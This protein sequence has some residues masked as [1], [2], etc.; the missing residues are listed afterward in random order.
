[1]LKKV[2][3]YYCLLALFCFPALAKEKI[4][5]GQWYKIKSEILQEMRPYSIYLPPTYQTQKDKLYPVIYV[6]D[7]DETKLKALSGLMESFTVEK[8]VVEH[9]IVAIPNI[10]IRERNLTPTNNK[11]V[12]KDKVLDDFGPVGNA[13]NFISFFEKELIPN[14]NLNFRT[15]P[16]RMLIGHS[17][18]GLFS[19]Y[20][21]LIKPNLFTDYL[22]IDPTSLWDNNFLNR[23]FIDLKYDEQ[24]PKANVY[25]SFANN[26]H[27][28]DIGKT[29]YLWG[30]EFSSRF[31]NHKSTTLKVKSQYFEQ[32]THGSVVEISWL[33]G[34]RHLNNINKL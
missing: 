21:L 16:K 8:Q 27:L 29:N 3:F 24:S 1:M 2:T 33:Y 4:I 9:I 15:S 30:R 13:D 31:E 32:E 25:F 34:L 17:F 6:L 28:G 18:A 14:I 10:G 20:T 26:S 11:F 7:G 22:I 12:F 23:K 5:T 19:A